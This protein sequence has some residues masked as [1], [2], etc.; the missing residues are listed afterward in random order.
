MLYENKPFDD[1]KVNP[2][3]KKRML[4]NYQVNILIKLFKFSFLLTLYKKLNRGGIFL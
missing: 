4:N 3:N 1:I 2:N